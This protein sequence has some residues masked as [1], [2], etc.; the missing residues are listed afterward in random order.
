VREE[1]GSWVLSVKDNGIGI[2]PEHVERIFVIFQRLHT[3]EKY[4]GTGIGLAMCKKI[5]EFHGGRIWLDTEHGSE[6]SGEGETPRTGTRICWALPVDPGQEETAD[7]DGAPAA[8]E[9]IAAGGLGQV[10]AAGLFV[11]NVWVRGRMRCGSRS[12]PRGWS[13]TSS[14]ATSTTRT[15]A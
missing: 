7:A 9:A 1:G 4:T 15:C 10:A 5:V 14:I 6:T 3:R 12:I 13:V 11:I 8:R 2:D